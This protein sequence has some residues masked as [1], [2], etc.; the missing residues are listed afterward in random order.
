MDDFDFFEHLS[1]SELIINVIYTI[2]QGS[3]QLDWSKLDL[4]STPV[5]SK[6]TKVPIDKNL[7]SHKLKSTKH[8]EISKIR[9]ELLELAIYLKTEN[10]KIQ[11]E[12]IKLENEKQTLKQMVS[13]KKELD[14]LHK[15]SESR[16][17]R[18]LNFKDKDI[19]KHFSKQQKILLQ[20][21]KD[22][23]NI[24]REL[25]AQNIKYLNDIH[26]RDK[27]IDR[28]NKQIEKYRIANRQVEFN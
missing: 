13:V 12:Y 17:N 4:N 28:K 2:I 14:F 1:K 11:S 6:K 27:Q 21:I 18:D 10:E 15:E 9:N 23:N 19:V 8:H 25:K 22:L 24:N 5:P 26:D 20:T 16:S 7:E 3:V